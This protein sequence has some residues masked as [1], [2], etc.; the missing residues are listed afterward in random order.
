[1]TRL[2]SSQVNHFCRIGNVLFPIF[3]NTNTEKNCSTNMFDVSALRVLFQ[4][5]PVFWS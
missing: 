1:M 5:C 3:V 4:C 2:G